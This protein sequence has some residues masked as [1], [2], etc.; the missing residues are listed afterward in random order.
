LSESGGWADK[1]PSGF[2]PK[3]RNTEEEGVRAG[4]V[5]NVRGK[6]LVF[7]AVEWH[8][9]G[10]VTGR[11][12]GLAT[13]LRKFKKVSP[14]KSIKKSISF[15]CYFYSSFQQKL[16]HLILEKFEL[17]YFIDSLFIL[18]GSEYLPPIFFLRLNQAK[19]CDQASLWPFT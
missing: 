2:H 1:R 5:E 13:I 11:M 10:A 12:R 14:A 4:G 15:I 3:W 9:G 6:T 16:K 7:V 8:E 19:Q 18:F 17:K